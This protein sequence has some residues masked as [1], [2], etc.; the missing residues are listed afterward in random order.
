MRTSRPQA[1]LLEKKGKYFSKIYIYIYEKAP[2]FWDYCGYQIHLIA[3]KILPKS[4]TEWLFVN[5]SF[6]INPAIDSVASEV[7][8]SARWATYWTE[9][10]KAWMIWAVFWQLHCLALVLY[11]IWI[12]L[13]VRW[14]LAEINLLSMLWIYWSMQKL[15]ICGGH[16]VRNMNI[17]LDS[18][19][20]RTEMP[21]FGC[22][23]SRLLRSDQNHS[24]CTT[25]CRSY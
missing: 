8:E 1:G 3:F 22:T 15:C 25:I 10:S 24:S 17:F 13:D 4:K 9:G 12:D 19:Q 23:C 11:R 7:V 20:Q 16:P 5:H 14:H 6:L 2:F 18:H 21:W